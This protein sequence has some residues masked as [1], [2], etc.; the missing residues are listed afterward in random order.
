MLFTTL[1]SS[2]SFLVVGFSGPRIVSQFDLGGNLGIINWASSFC[3]LFA[4]S[5]NNCF[6]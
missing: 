2:V 1:I 6:S 5:L 4:T 3:G